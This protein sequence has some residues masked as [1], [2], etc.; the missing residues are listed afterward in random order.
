M[1]TTLDLSPDDVAW[2]NAWHPNLRFDP[3]EKTISGELSFCAS[4]DKGTGQLLIE[5][6][7]ISAELRE[8]DTF[9]CDAFEIIIMLNC[10][11]EWFKGWPKTIEVGGRTESIAKKRDVVLAD[12]HTYVDGACCLGFR[13]T[14]E[15]DRTIRR[16]L[17]SLVIPHFYRL[18]YSDRYGID[19]LWGEYAH[20]TGLKQ[21]ISDLNNNIARPS[22]GRNKPCPCG[23]G[24]KYKK[25][26]LAEIEAMRVIASKSR[27]PGRHPWTGAG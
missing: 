21:Y 27:A 25:C 15:R 13:F 20:D 23:S 9:I 1:G 22:K 19:P 16:F 17:T 24:F 10:E 18:S 4:F 11:V 26:C 2:L 7:G 6:T 8:M 12:L 3:V 14:P 5:E